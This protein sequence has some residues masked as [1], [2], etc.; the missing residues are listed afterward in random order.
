[1]GNRVQRTKTN[2]PIFQ[3]TNAVNEGWKNLFG[4]TPSKEQ[5]AMVLAQNALETGNRKNMWNYNVGNI[6]TS[7]KG[8]YNYF[9]DLTTNEQV[10]NGV[11]KKKNLKYRA[12]SSLK[13]GVKDYLKLLSGGKYSNAWQH[14]L[15]PNPIAFSKSLKESGYYTADEA[16]YTKALAKLF[17]QY[18]NVQK[19]S[20]PQNDNNL[21]NMLNT[22]LQMVAA[23][24]KH[25]YKK[26]LPSN[27]IVVQVRSDSFNNSVEFA[28]VLSSALEEE[29]QAKAYIH[30]NGEEIE[31]QCIISGPAQDCANTVQQLAESLSEVFTQATKKIGGIKVLS[32]VVLNKHSSYKELDLVIAEQQHKKFLL[33]FI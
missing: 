30:T 20:I 9:D 32:H 13:E 4:I 22:Y 21:D 3:M 7:G 17:N 5:V 18:A 6:T 15:H 14:I 27:N 12:Y 11:W 29:L 10:S 26:L 25:I 16:P 1:M 8:A 31:I 24:E 2:V 23:S 33:K 19:T 28:R